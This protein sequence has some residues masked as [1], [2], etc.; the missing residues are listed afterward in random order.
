MCVC[1][2]VCV[3]LVRHINHC[4]LFNVK[5]IFKNINS[6]VSNDSILNKYPV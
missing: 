2:C 1:V 6:L 3:C 4:K 5:S